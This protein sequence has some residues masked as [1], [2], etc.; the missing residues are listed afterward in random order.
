[1]NGAF[2]WFALAA[3]AGCLAIS[4]YHRHRARVVAGAIPRGREAPLLILGRVAVA[5]VDA[6]PS[7]AD[8]WSRLRT[9]DEL[10]AERARVAADLQ[11]DPDKLLAFTSSMP[12][13]YGDSDTAASAWTCPMHPEVVSATPDTCPKCGM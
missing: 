11:R 9:S 2:R 6:S 1:M 13:L 10:T 4:V 12:L 5:D 3:L 7:Y 8:D